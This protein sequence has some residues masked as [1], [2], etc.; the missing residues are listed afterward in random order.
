MAAATATA[1]GAI[2]AAPPDAKAAM[3]MALTTAA[4]LIHLHIAMSLHKDLMIIYRNPA[5]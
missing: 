5:P 3:V 2:N 4:V 1:I